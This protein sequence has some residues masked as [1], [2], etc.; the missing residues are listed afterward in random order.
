MTLDEIEQEI[1]IMHLRLHFE[2]N[3]K[4]ISKLEMELGKLKLYEKK[5]KKFI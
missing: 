5:V 2:D 4:L 1:K 3:P